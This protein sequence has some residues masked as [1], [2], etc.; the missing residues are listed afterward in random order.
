MLKQP[1]KQNCTSLNES[2]FIIKNVCPNVK[3]IGEKIFLL[4][5]GLKFI[6]DKTANNELLTTQLL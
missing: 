4:S 5:N 2:L 1:V 3:I 6:L